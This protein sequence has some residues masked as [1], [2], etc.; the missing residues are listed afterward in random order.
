MTVGFFS[1]LP[2]ARTGVAD[3]SAALLQELRKTG[4]VDIAPARCDV[5]LY[6]TG[7]NALHAEIYRRALEQPGIAVIHDAV[8][9]HFLLGQLD[10][11]Q[12]IDEFVFNYGEWHR[13]LARELWHARASSAS[14]PRYFEYPLLRRMAERS[15]AVIVHN[16][17]AATVVR[18]HAPGAPV[19]EIP[20]LHEPAPRLMGAEIERYR[21]NLGVPSDWFLFGVF[22]YLRETKRVA[23]IVDAFTQLRRE[24]PN[25]ALLL[26]GDFV[27][28]DLERAMLPLLGRP[29]IVRKPYLPDH[30][31][32]LAAS[33]VDACINLKYPAAGETSGI[34][35]RLMGLAKPVLLTASPESARYPDDACLR[36]PAGPAE[37]PSLL[38]HMRLLTAMPSVAREI[39]RRAAAHIL[40]HHDIA[41]VAGMYWAALYESR[42]VL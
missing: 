32:W 15:L 14:D 31:F 9:H 10:E 16:P 12:Y 25:T 42:V 35:I 13:Q 41:R 17:A 1:P 28:R 24:R 2:P 21:Q 5:A 33:C 29:G 18:K 20:H 6:Q 30:E 8:L 34:A 27:S 19:I 22:G 38:H 39:G 11:R 36:I 40:T 4:R 7:N 37:R 26:A 23:Q 3:Y